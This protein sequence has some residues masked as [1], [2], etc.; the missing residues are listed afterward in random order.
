MLGKEMQF[1]SWVHSTELTT[2]NDS[3]AK[4]KGG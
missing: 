2:V 4:K 1:P 3:L